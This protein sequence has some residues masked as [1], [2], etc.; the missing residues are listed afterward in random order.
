[1]LHPVV[2]NDETCENNDS[3]VEY[4]NDKSSKP[5]YWELYGCGE[6]NEDVAKSERM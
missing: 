3:I 1:M 5:K 6:W 2:V 4:K